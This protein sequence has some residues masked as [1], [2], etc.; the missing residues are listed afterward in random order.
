MISQVLP[1]AI[2]VTTTTSHATPSA[3]QQA[4]PNSGNS[5]PGQ[6]P[7][8]R[9][10]THTMAAGDT[11]AS[12]PG[13]SIPGSGSHVP[14]RLSSRSSGG[15]LTPK[16]WQPPPRS[17]TQHQNSPSTQPQLTPTAAA[18]AVGRAPISTS[19]GAA[20]EVNGSRVQQPHGLYVKTRLGQFYSMEGTPRFT[21]INV[22]RALLGFK[23]VFWFGTHDDVCCFAAA[24][25]PA[26]PTAVCSALLN[27][28]NPDIHNDIPAC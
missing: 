16:T 14:E 5:M 7:R 12:I 26:L 1:P 23:W 6:G 15:R 4:A 8:L 21:G 22:V 25:P 11:S 10:S 3:S 13:S 2:N 28:L 19:V 18:H 17:A 27:T 24:V 20:A 9:D